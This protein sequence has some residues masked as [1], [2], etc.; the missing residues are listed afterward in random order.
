MQPCRK[1]S[2]GAFGKTIGQ[3]AGGGLVLAGGTSIGSRQ[4]ATSSQ[5]LGRGRQGPSCGAAGHAVA[6]REAWVPF[7]KGPWRLVTSTP[8][9]A[10]PVQ[11]RWVCS[12]ADVS[13]PAPH[14]GKMLGRV[15]LLDGEMGSAVPKL[16][17]LL[18]EPC[19]PGQRAR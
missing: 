13:N 3:R 10:A 2:P 7:T 12:G 14:R 19:I 17:G 15:G 11:C 8:R 18:G 16:G 5:I 6:G 9:G 1:P 4:A